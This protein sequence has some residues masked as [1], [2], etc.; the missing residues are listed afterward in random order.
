MLLFVHIII[1]VCAQ[2]VIVCAH[3]VTLCAVFVPFVPGRHFVPGFLRTGYLISIFLRDLDIFLI[4]PSFLLFKI[5][6][7]D[8]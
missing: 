6:C 2:Y 8:D 5:N 7:M 3:N 4:L 1:T